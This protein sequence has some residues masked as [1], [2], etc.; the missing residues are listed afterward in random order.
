MRETNTT[1]ADSHAV[2]AVS[3]IVYCP[4]LALQQICARV[5]STTNARLQ[6]SRTCQGEQYVGGRFAV[7]PFR[8]C[9]CL[10]DPIAY[11]CADPLNVG[12]CKLAT[13]HY[14]IPRTLKCRDDLSDPVLGL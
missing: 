3:P 13:V 7:L 1:G 12:V 2:A 11:R 5:K 9:P 14:H 10:F 8:L 6:R 4:L